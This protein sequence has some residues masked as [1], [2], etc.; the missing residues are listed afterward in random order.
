VKPLLGYGAAHKDKSHVD[1]Y[2]APDNTYDSYVRYESECIEDRLLSLEA[3]ALDPANHQG[4]LALYQH[5]L[6]HFGV[7]SI[8]SIVPKDYLELIMD[9]RES[10]QFEVTTFTIQL[11][12]YAENVTAIDFA[13]RFGGMTDERF[14]K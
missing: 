1:S 3:G 8:S 6:T 4:L 11:T 14:S 5:T 2:V 13:I 7:S 10:G 9:A 12:G